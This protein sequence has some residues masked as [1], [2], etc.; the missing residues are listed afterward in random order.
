MSEDARTTLATLG[1]LL[2]DLLLLDDDDG[3][4]GELREQRP[5]LCRRTALCCCVIIRDVIDALMLRLAANIY[6]FFCLC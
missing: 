1:V 2:P 5:G 4:E 3:G 6:L